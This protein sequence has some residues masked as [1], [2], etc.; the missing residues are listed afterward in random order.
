MLKKKGKK[1]IIHLYMYAR[2][3]NFLVNIIYSPLLFSLLLI[4]N[5]DYW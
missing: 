3:T 4:H 1:V 2:K 5:K